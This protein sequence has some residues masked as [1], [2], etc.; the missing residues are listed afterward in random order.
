MRA[1]YYGK[2]AGVFPPTPE[3]PPEQTASI[4]G[5]LRYEDVAQDGRLL[6]TALPHFMGEAVFHTLL[7]KRPEA[8]ANAHAGII[9]ILTR[10]TIEGGGGPV[11]VRRPVTA[12][13]GYQMAHT[14]DTDGRVNRLLLNTWAS[15][16]APVGRTN[17]PQPPNAGEPVF[18]GRVF[19]EHVLTRPFAPREERKVLRMAEGPWPEV[20]EDRAPWRPYERMLELPM[21][22]RPLD[23]G[24]EP[25]DAP[26]VF[27]LLHTD[28]NQHVN[29]LVYPRLFEE[30]V[31][32]R[33]AAHGR[34]SAF[35]ARFIDTAY[36]KPCFAGQRV[37]VLLRAYERE[38]R[39]GA[40]G[41][42][43]PEDAR[44]ARPHAVTLLES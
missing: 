43:V 28:S 42:F 32:R 22:A 37:R 10:L 29:S 39:P 12:A 21:G 18:V 35:L 11:S 24:L 19:G 23:G 1:L 15:M 8:R 17:P 31:A 26:I 14:V 6:L 41:V 27:S 7:R 16:T 9:P 34:D 3:V 33:L 38:G 36:R 30:A 13:G 44:G 20:P 4:E 5:F 2:V 40:V 25:D